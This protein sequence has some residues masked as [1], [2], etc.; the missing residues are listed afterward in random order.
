MQ[1]NSKK[2]ILL[3]GGSFDPIH[4]GHLHIAHCAA[5]ILDVEKVVFIPAGMPPHKLDRELASPKDRYEMVRRAVQFDPL[6]GVSDYEVTLESPSF[7][8]HTVRFFRSQFIGYELFWLIGADSFAQ[9]DKWYNIG[10]LVELCNVVTVG[11]PG[12]DFSMDHLMDKLTNDQLDKLQK[13]IIDIP[14]TEESSTQIREMVGNGKSVCGL[15]PDA[16]LEYII[17]NGLYK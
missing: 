12:F 13:Y 2:S 14:L 4:N 8:V 10:K 9:L 1:E 16:V 6:C 11:R 3:Y 15:V 17:S 7:T 5:E